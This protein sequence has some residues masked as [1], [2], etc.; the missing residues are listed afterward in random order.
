[1]I[2]CPLC[3]GVPGAG[4]RNGTCRCKALVRWS[5]DG[6]PTWSF[7]TV[8]CPMVTMDEWGRVEVWNDPA[9]SL[10][11]AVPEDR[12]E[13]MVRSVV[14]IPDREERAAVHEVLGS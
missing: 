8:G 9:L 14:E 2:L 13:A 10:G 3:G 4:S 11:G 12:A 1:M 6:G 7:G 5:T